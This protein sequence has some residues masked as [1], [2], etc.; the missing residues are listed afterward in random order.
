MSFRWGMPAPWECEECKVSLT[1]AQLR[2]PYRYYESSVGPCFVVQGMGAWYDFQDL[3]TS[4]L[5]VIREDECPVVAGMTDAQKALFF[6]QRLAAL[7]AEESRC[8]ADPRL[9][10]TH[11]VDAPVTPTEPRRATISAGTGECP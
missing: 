8:N 7:I 4:R 10:A 6:S 3:R 5:V 11:G 1:A 9:W 2:T